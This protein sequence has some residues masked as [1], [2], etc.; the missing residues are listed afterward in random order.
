VTP[1]PTGRTVAYMILDG[2]SSKRSTIQLS[3]RE[4]VVRF[5]RLYLY[6]KAALDPQCAFFA[7]LANHNEESPNCEL[8]TP[9]KE[10]GVYRA[11]LI[12]ICEAKVGEW[13]TFNYGP[14]QA[15]DNEEARTVKRRREKVAQS[16][17]TFTYAGIFA[18]CDKCKKKENLCGKSKA[19]RGPMATR[20]TCDV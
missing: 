2:S 16:K 5:G 1:I 7:H 15:F 9:Y 10:G 4:F 19:A 11:E 14:H 6:P 12:T 18:T 20:H 13:L 17:P 3:Y 8:K